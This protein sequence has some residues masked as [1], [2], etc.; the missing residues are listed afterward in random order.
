MK[1]KSRNDIFYH[2]H[3]Y[4]WKCLNVT[5]D[6]IMQFYSVVDSANIR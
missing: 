2:L 4:I 5:I 6:Y 3:R 1:T